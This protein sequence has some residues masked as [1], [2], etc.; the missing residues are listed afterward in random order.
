[1]PI[2]GLGSFTEL[3][4]L[5]MPVETRSETGTRTITYQTVEEVWARQTQLDGREAYYADQLAP[6]ATCQ[7][8]LVYRDDVEVG[9]RLVQGSSEY[10]I[11]RPPIPD[12]KH[13][14][15]TVYCVDMKAVRAS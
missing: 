5:Q 6:Q 10:E 15:I 14:I 7:F 8:D 2:P 9:W 11:K 4:I 12:R 1:M 13:L 3:M